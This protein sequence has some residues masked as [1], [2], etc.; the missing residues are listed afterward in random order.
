MYRAGTVSPE[1]NGHSP[2]W[3]RHEERVSAPSKRDFSAQTAERKRSLCAGRPFV[4]QNHLG[5]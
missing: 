3:L 4:L 5:R 2:E 1:I